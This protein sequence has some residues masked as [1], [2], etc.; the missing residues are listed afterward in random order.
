MP[1]YETDTCDECGREIIARYMDAGLCPD[2]A[3]ER[4]ECVNC[5]REF[6]LGKM[7]R[8]FAGWMCEACAKKIGTEVAHVAAICR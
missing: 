2:C 1:Q 8:T 3:A 6:R 4:G 5:E 7:E